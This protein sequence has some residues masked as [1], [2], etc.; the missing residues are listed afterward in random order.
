MQIGIWPHPIT[1][2]IHAALKAVAAQILFS[3]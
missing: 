1:P 2:E 3:K